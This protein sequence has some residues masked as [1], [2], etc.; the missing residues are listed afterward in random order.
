MKQY[1]NRAY[2]NYVK[3]LPSVI[4]KRPGDDAHHLVGHGYSG[5]A[6]KASDLWVFPLTRDEH[7]DLHNI[8]YKAWEE[9]YG[10][11]WKFIVLT[12]TQALADGVIKL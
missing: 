1:R 6:I 12:I 4:S 5:M 9:K 7:T 10:S 8:G 2:L 11:Q 3:Q